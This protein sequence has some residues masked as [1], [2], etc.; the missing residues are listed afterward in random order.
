MNKDKLLC[1]AGQM[2]AASPEG[3]MTDLKLN[4]LIEENQI[5]GVLLFRRSCPDSD[6]VRALVE[7]MQRRAKIPLL[8]MI[9]QEGGRVMR[10]MEDMFAL[11]PA[12]ELSKQT[13]EQVENDTRLLGKRLIELGINCNLAPVLDVDSNL[14][15]PVIGD[16]SFGDNVDTV[17][18]Y[19]KAYRKG[20]NTSGVIACG[21]HFPGHGDTDQDSHL[22]LPVVRHSEERLYNLEIEPFKRAVDDGFEMI[23]VAHVLYESLDLDEP[24]TLSQKISTGILREKLGFKGVTIA[25]D[26]E[27]KAIAERYPVKE[28]VYK[29]INAGMD[30]LPVCHSYELAFDVHRS[31]VTL[32]ED[33][34]IELDRIKDSYDRIMQ[35]KRLFKLSQ[36][37]LI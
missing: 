11:P 27:M 7:A 16:R 31:I 5:G 36:D 22:T 23:M 6:S 9:D 1:Y 35:M 26:L 33:G 10:L 25:D 32:V 24:A 19:A 12:R 20:L 34:S 17:F 4:R 37:T 30:I 21:K 18:E 13:L 14:Q 15:N 29:L 3:A 8:V 28:L 2:V